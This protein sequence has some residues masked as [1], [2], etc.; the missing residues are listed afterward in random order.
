MGKKTNFTQI[1]LKLND[2]VRHEKNT[3]RVAEVKSRRE[4]DISTGYKRVGQQ[5]EIEED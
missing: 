4:G 5:M 1:L 2:N 3:T